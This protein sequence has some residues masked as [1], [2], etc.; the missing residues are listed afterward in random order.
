MHVAWVDDVVN[1]LNHACADTCLQAAAMMSSMPPE[2]LAALGQQFGHKVDP[3]Q[4]NDAHTKVGDIR[5][6]QLEALAAMAEAGTSSGAAPDMQETLKVGLGGGGALPSDA[7]LTPATFR[8]AS[9]WMGIRTPV[10]DQ[11]A[12]SI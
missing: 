12:A 2:Q 6:E 4:L 8:V 5:P 7:S 1:V 9:I 3:S 10:P 11:L